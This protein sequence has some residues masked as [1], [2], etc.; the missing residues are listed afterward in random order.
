M[1]HSK[2]GDAHIEVTEFQKQSSFDFE[3]ISMNKGFQTTEGLLHKQKVL[4][5]LVKTE[6]NQV[7]K[8]IQSSIVN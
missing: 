7:I 4:Q 2:D 1:F 8:E 3:V 5:Y 6:K